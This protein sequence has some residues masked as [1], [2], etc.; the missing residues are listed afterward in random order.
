MFIREAGLGGGSFNTSSAKSIKNTTSSLT[1]QI[2]NNGNIS[3]NINS[4]SPGSSVFNSIGNLASLFTGNSDN[5]NAFNAAEAQKNRDFQER[6]SNTAYQ[7]MVKDLQKAGLNPV[8]ASYG[9]GA[10]TPSGSTAYADTSSNSAIAS[11]INGAMSMLSAQAVANIYTSASLLQAQMNNDTSKW[12]AKYNGGLQKHIESIITD[13]LSNPEKIPNSGKS[14][15]NKFKEGF[16][17]GLNL[18]NINLPH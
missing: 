9:N 11:V 13:F 8:L 14:W 12:I 15:F 3:R 17:K 16:E 10:S 7:R 2:N 18:Y 1:N 5:N 4:S 6:M